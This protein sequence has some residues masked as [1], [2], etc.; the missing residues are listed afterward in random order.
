MTNNEI[1]AIE[2]HLDQGHM[3]DAGRMIRESDEPDRAILA[4]CSR[5]VNDGFGCRDLQDYID[6]LNGRMSR[7]ARALNAADHYGYTTFPNV[8]N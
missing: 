2:R 7:I 4:L 6:D 8:R 5:A 3:A 1:V